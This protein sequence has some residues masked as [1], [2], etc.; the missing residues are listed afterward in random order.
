MRKI[1]DFKYIE[2]CILL[3]DC[4]LLKIFKGFNID[5]WIEK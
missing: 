1:L 3:Y 2:L 5:V 4:V